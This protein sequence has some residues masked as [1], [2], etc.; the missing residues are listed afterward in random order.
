MSAASD[1]SAPHEGRAMV[2]LVTHE[3]DEL[4]WL[5]RIARWKS[6]LTVVEDNPSRSR[7]RC[8][9]RA[10]AVRDDYEADN[11]ARKQQRI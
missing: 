3:L 1:V 8:S 11:Q 7:S 10:Q 4:R 6:S 5:L 9:G 2:L